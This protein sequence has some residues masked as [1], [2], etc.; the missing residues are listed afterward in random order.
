MLG[1]PA[2]GAWSRPDRRASLRAY[3][4]IDKSRFRNEAY[5]AQYEVGFRNFGTTPANNVR[6]ARHD[7][8]DADDD[9]PF[10]IGPDFQSYGPLSPG[11]ITMALYEEDAD[12]DTAQWNSIYDGSKVLY[13]FGE[14]LSRDVF[15][16]TRSLKF[17]LKTKAR[18]DSAKAELW[19][20]PRRKRS[21]L[22]WQRYHLIAWR[23]E[24]AARTSSGSWTSP[25]TEIPRPYS[26]TSGGRTPSR[27]TRGAGFFEQFIG[28]VVPG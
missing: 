16:R 6:P 22:M 14:I 1:D 11:Q 2:A 3:L 5:Y 18:F 27:G 23:S 25:A 28:V 26:V 13:V 21:N 15:D 7:L 4:G 8:R 17:R 9:R 10:T 24:G 19:S 12:F 20:L